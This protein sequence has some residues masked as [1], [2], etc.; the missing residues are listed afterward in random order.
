[1]YSHCGREDSVGALWYKR[2][3][4][5]IEIGQSPRDMFNLC[6]KQYHNAY[7]FMRAVHLSLVPAAPPALGRSAGSY[8]RT[9]H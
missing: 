7:E 9:A 4:P 3:P 6:R 8:F 5:F 2:A 1:M